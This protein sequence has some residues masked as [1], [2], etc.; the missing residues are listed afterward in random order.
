[1]LCKLQST[2]EF[3]HTDQVVSEEKL[4]SV[5]LEVV[6]GSAVEALELVLVR[7]GKLESRER[8]D[9]K[10]GVSFSSSFLR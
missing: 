7:Q 5:I 1:M 3:R 6:E 9:Q 10:V 4:N 8:N 2:V